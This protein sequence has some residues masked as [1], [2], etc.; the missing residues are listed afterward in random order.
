MDK[1]ITAGRLSAGA[2]TGVAVLGVTIIARFNAL[3]DEPIT[4]ACGDTGAQTGVGVLRVAVIASLT[5]LMHRSITAGRRHAR[6]QAAVRIFC[7]P[8]I[9]GLIRLNDSVPADGVD[10]VRQRTGADPEPKRWQQKRR[11]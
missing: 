11:E 5:V 6:A 8:V 1:P 10:G 3:V 7:V 4:A 2:W 9:A